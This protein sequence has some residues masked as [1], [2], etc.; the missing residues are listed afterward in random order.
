MKS[1]S[2]N[3]IAKKGAMT[4]GI[5]GSIAFAGVMFYAMVIGL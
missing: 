2:I 5:I 1:N 4:L 3:D